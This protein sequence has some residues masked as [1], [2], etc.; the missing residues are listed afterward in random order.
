MWGCFGGSTAKKPP[1]ILVVTAIPK[2]PIFEICILN[3]SCG[4]I[5]RAECKIPPHGEH[6]KGRR[7]GRPPFFGAS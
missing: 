3:D 6:K 1:H 2:D 7:L 5:L 4:G